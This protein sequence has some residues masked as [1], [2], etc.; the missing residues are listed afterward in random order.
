MFWIIINLYKGY[1]I[2]SISYDY[3]YELEGKLIVL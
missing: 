3:D 2:K 1:K